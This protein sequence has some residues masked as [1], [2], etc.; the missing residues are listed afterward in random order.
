MKTEVLIIG[1]GYY[2]VSTACYLAEK[3]IP[4]VILGKPFALWYDHILDKTYLRS[5]IVETEMRVPGNPYN[6]V[7]FLHDRYPDKAEKML[8]EDLPIDVFRAYLTFIEKNLPFDIQQIMVTHVSETDKG[9]VSTLSDGT[10]IESNAVVLA[11]GVGPHAS[12]PQSLKHLSPVLHAWEVGRYE[13]LKHKRIMIVG[14]GQ[15]AAEIIKHLEPHNKIVWVTRHK[16]TYYSDPIHVPNWLFKLMIHLS[17]YLYF[18]KGAL[19]KVV[20]RNMYRPT[21]TP[22]HEKVLNSK[23]IKTVHADVNAMGLK[24]KG[25]TIVSKNHEVEVDLIISATGYTYTIEN[26]GFLSKEIRACAGKRKQLVNFNFESS[27]HNLF[28]VGGITE[29][30]HGV[31]QRFL[32][33]ARHAGRRVARVLAR[34]I[35]V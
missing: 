16:P 20:P 34:R 3:K 7:T 12:L 29:E 32:F 33:G 4:F 27:V 21:I 13:S 11:T 17:P 35:R 10:K 15:S 6:L 9:F 18:L 22:R 26:V 31:A 25:A 30:A 1:A 24:K 5:E 2:G 28:V 8:E 23:N 19:R 14:S